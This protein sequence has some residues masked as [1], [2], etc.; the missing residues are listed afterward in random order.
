MFD[1]CELE[2]LPVC[3]DWVGDQVPQ[4]AWEAGS[5]MC[6]ALSF[7]KTGKQSGKQNNCNQGEYWRVS[8]KMLDRN[9]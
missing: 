6:C 8:G 2:R 3:L 9:W 4:V 5:V 1:S 7:M